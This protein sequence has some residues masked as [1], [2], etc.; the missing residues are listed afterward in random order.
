[1]GAND[2]K[3]A[4]PDRLELPTLI[5]TPEISNKLR[6]ISAA[7][8][9]ALFTI[10]DNDSAVMANDELQRVKARAK[11]LDTL[12]KGFVA[13]ARTILDNA[14]AL[15]NPAIESCAKAESIL[16]GALLTWTQAEAARV[17]AERRQREDAERAARQR[18]QEE[19][20]AAQRRAQE[21]AASKRREAEEA[22]RQRVAAVA[23]GNAAAAQ[24]AAA[25]T[26]AL[27]QQ[28]EAAVENGNAEAQASLILAAAVPE[29]ATTAPAAKMKGLST[30]KNWGAELAPNFTEE[31]AK[32]AICR[33]IVGFTEDIN[34]KPV[35][36]PPR[37]DLLGLLSLDMSAANKLAK[38]LEHN[39]NVPGLVARNN[40]AVASR[41]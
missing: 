7:D 34:G 30:R 9:A 29:A 18:A 2:L 39:T 40:P 20:A 28:A 21:E 37:A 6:D 25:R 36:H 24:E 13:P 32:L 23:A 22:E 35:T 3:T 12:R 10:T 31:T 15:F 41:G 5:F 27:Q 19:A 14:A 11:E 17:A 8:T 38:A 26:A 1:M 16:K 33:A 4:V